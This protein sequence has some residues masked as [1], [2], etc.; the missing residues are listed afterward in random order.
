MTNNEDI[1]IKPGDE[2]VLV[3]YYDHAQTKESLD[4][5]RKNPPL[6]WC[7]GK[8]VNKNTDDPFHCLI[9]TGAIGR[10]KKPL[11]RDIIMKNCIK[12]IEVIFTIP[13]GFDKSRQEYI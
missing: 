7:I 13:I 10:F 12:S 2:I 11:W 3:V 1:K 6:L 8:I 5:I 9:N 4:Q